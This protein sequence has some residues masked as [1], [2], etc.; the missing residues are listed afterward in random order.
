MSSN[1]LILNIGGKRYE[2]TRQTIELYPDTLLDMLLKRSNKEDEEIFIDRDQK[3][4]RWILHY[5][6][7]GNM[8]NHDDVGVSEHVWLDELQFYGL[9]EKDEQH[10]KK[11]KAF[12]ECEKDIREKAE[13]IA[14]KHDE[15][16]DKE[17]IA[18]RKTYGEIMSFM[19]D[20]LELRVRHTTF[21]FI[22]KPKGKE[23]MIHGQGITVDIVWLEPWFFEFGKF[24][25]ELGYE[26]KLINSSEGTTSRKYEFFPASKTNV[27]NLHSYMKIQVKKIKE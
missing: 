16:M 9:L 2:T 26:I 1:K 22:G 20:H 24:A 7:T 5:Y 6:R 17:M 14:K 15:E 23:T 21:E 27:P 3:L 10:T 19:L 18:R 12:L 4:F 13:K 25:L 11:R 8:V